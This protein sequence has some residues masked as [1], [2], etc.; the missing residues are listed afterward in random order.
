MSEETADETFDLKVR[1]I[2]DDEGRYCFIAIRI[3]YEEI[4][5]RGPTLDSAVYHLRDLLYKEDTE[6]T[7]NGTERKLTLYCS[8]CGKS[9]HEVRKLIAGPTVFI[10]DECTELCDDIVIEETFPDRVVIRV[11]I[12]HFAEFEE[13]ALLSIEELIRERFSEI[14]FRYEFRTDQISKGADIDGNLVCYSFKKIYGNDAEKAV[15]QKEY[16]KIGEELRV[17]VS[18]LA[19][20][21]Q[22]YR[23][24]NKRL[25][26]VSRELAEL[27][28]EYLDHLRKEKLLDDI[29]EDVRAVMFLDVAGFSTLDGFQKQQMLDML[30]GLVPP[31]LTGRGAN[32]VNMW[33][34]G[35]VSNF[36]DPAVAVECAVKFMKHLSV[37]HLD[38]RIGI[39]WG[40]VRISRNIATGKEDID[41]ATVDFAARLET[42]ADQGSV[43]LSHEFLGLDIDLN[44]VNVVPSKIVVRK[45]FADKE[46]GDEIEVCKLRILSN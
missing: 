35:I 9:Q 27:K 19:V 17:A 16:E 46:V 18:K 10:C 7:R 23:A 30:R 1:R 24:E 39:A 13:S 29:H 41:G 3:G 12:P 42:F 34:D 5:G 26:K 8:F 22:R 20:A 40:P 31:L 15:V 21:T 44:F 43:L 37:E 4:E 38:C 6:N 25:E 11:N 33:G 45:A 14:D 2:L 28:S 32:Q 36:D